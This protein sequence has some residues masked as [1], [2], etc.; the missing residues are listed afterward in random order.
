MATPADA[1]P[2]SF[3]EK[4]ASGPTRLRL[5]S[6]G[7]EPGAAGKKDFP[8]VGI[9]ASAGGL[10]A[11]E[12]FFSGMPSGHAMNMAFVLVQHLAP[13]HKSM[14]SEL[15]RRI[16]SMTVL[17]VE[18]GMEVRRNCAY[19]I[20][21]GR[22]MALLGGT[23]QLLEP[24]APR[25]QRM[26]IDFFFRSL[27][28]DRRERAIGIVLSGTGTDG[29]MGVRAIKGAGGM[30]MVQDPAT[31]EYD[32]MPRSALA[33]GLVDY[34]LAPRQMASH[35]L[36]YVNRALARPPAPRTSRPVKTESAL[37]K[38]FVLIRTHI[39]HD[40]SQYKPST[41]HRRIERRMAVHQ[42]ETLDQYIRFIQETPDE[43]KAL[44]R[45]LLIGVTNFFRDPDAFKA[46]EEKVIPRLFTG[47]PANHYIRIWIPGCATGEEAYSLAILLA[48]HQESLKRN[49]RFQIFATDIDSRSIAIARNGLYPVSIAA[50]LSAERLARYFTAEPDGLAFR[51]HKSIR[52]MLVFSEQ[53]VI[54]DPPFSKVDLICCRNLLIYLNASL[55]RKLIPL[56]NYALNPG[57]FLFLGS[58]ETVSE[59]AHLFE[60]VDRRQK[61]F[62]HKGNL[63]GIHQTLPGGFL[64][65]MMERTALPQLQGKAP[66]LTKA[67]LR[68]LTEHYLLQEYVPPAALV[69]GSGDIL[70]FHGRTGLYLEP[71]PGDAGINNILKMAREGLK[72]ELASA[73]HRAVTGREPVCCP[74]LQVK[75]NG[76]YTTVKMSI[77]PVDSGLPGTGDTRLF[78]ILFEAAPEK[79]EDEKSLEEP[80]PGDEEVDTRIAALQMELRA[81]EEYLQ[82]A[83]EELETANEELKS[84]N[85]EMQSVNEELQS[86][87]E[88]LETSKEEM[89]S[90]NEEL[91]TVNNELQAKVADLS[92]ANNDMNN[93]LAGTGIATVFVDHALHILRFTPAA[94]RII[95]LIQSDLGR[96]VGHLASNLSGYDRLLEDIRAVLDTLVPKDVEVQTRAGTWYAMRIQPYRTMENV[97]EGA[98][99]TFVDINQQKQ[100]QL[101]LQVSEARFRTLVLASSDAV[102]RMS[103][104]WKEM[105]YLRGMDFLPDTEEPSR[106]W[107]QKYIPVED[108]AFVV[109]VIHRAIRNKEVFELTHRILLLDGSYGMTLSRAVPMVNERGEIVEWFGTAKD[110]SRQSRDPNIIPKE[111][112]P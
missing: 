74:G 24:A 78:L 56:F 75:T 105:K 5:G 41:I 77:F 101:D 87:N 1:G 88:E 9:G 38:I 98:V 60:A 91:A 45:D 76:G 18:D 73:L 49:Y 89:Q 58:S 20:P 96:P 104:D 37:N 2:S 33:T 102:Y 10:S 97:I 46:L 23:L 53:D 35:L 42:I 7:N 65:P 61:I 85:E 43:V 44:F 22:D 28:Q 17:E 99:I 15:I 54:R 112:Q 72:H 25:G 79:G 16:T 19:I 94:T 111:E 100:M 92:R 68:E 31:T 71:A 80:P 86:T 109:E 59:F 26:P 39:G 52:D 36:S 93:L 110:I 47:K 34:K 12:T 40:F 70:Y 63:K 62:Q 108:Q 13:D 11:F 3:K 66:E 57:G 50:D 84:S 21:P 81:K 32:G 64:P 103:S 48:E 83:N 27:A 30:V 51:I 4:P 29:T 69:N 8:V 55:Q 82:S 106:T 107:L 6:S 67:P 14:L 95:N 90:I